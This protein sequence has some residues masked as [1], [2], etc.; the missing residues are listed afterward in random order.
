MQSTTELN[1]AVVKRFNEAFLIKGDLQ[2]YEE[3]VAADFINHTAPPGFAND[4]ESVKT[5]ITEGLQ[6]SFS[7]LS[8]EIH[9]MIAE[10]DRVMTHKT[11]SGILVG[12]LL[13]QQP[14]NKKTTLR[15]IDIIQLRDG[16]YIGHWSIREMKTAE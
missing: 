3:I 5:F 13:G 10:D 8:L 1:K 7:N 9:D 12:P 16:K 2:A 15:I 4:R 14:T 6:K 11:F